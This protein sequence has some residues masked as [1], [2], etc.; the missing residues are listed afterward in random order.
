MFYIYNTSCVKK[1]L[2]KWKMIVINKFDIHLVG[3]ILCEKLR[4]WLD[5]QLF[6]N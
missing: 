6:I 2:Q 5:Q 1:T 3:K 4:L